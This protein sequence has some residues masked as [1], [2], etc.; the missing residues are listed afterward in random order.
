MK[1]KK[2]A[3]RGG[4]TPYTEMQHVKHFEKT[5][6]RQKV[7]F[8]RNFLPKK[9]ICT[10][11]KYGSGQLCMYMDMTLLPLSGTKTEAALITAL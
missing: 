11:Y 2:Y 9:T 3:G 5:M 7:V 10:I 8:G 6:L 1:R 4:Y